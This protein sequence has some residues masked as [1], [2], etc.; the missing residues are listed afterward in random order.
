MKFKVFIDSE[1]EIIGY[2][3][4]AYH[5]SLA[6]RFIDLVVWRCQTEDGFEF[7]CRP[8]GTVEEKR[9]MLL[10]AKDQIGKMLTVRYQE[11]TDDGVPRFPV[12]VGIRDYE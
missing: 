7:N 6:N 9:K 5:D 8:K 3:K 1:Y 10:N 11:L 12:G 4:E 2:E